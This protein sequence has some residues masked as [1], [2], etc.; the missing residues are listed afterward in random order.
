M[1]HL[2]RLAIL[3]LVWVLGLAPLAARAV[4]IWSWSFDQT[5]YVVGPSDSIIVHATLLNDPSS[6]EALQQIEGVSAFFTGD[7]QKT[8]GFTFGPTGDS[9]E[10]STQFFSVDLAPGETFSFVWGILT[11]IGGAVAPGIYAAD[12]ASLGLDLP[13]ADLA[14]MEPTNTFRVRVVPE[15]PAVILLLTAI[16]GALLFTCPP[17]TAGRHSQLDGTQR[18]GRKACLH[19]WQSPE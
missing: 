13:G 15:P 6:T 19:D 2:R 16:L 8:Y 3:A 14:Q 1:K 18:S 4:V 10:F 11:P 5:E 7:L 17:N 12:P 9:S